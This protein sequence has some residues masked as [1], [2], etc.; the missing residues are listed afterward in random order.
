[1]MVY[2][3]V[4]GG[5]PDELS[6]IGPFTSRAVADTVAE[7]IK[8][9]NR[10]RR[11]SRYSSPLVIEW[12]VDADVE[13]WAAGLLPYTARGHLEFTIWGNSADDDVNWSPPG[14]QQERH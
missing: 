10:A 5:C 3:V 13:Q 6:Q 12:E 4:T 2:M 7:S 14:G 11:L 8:R 9:H 1:M